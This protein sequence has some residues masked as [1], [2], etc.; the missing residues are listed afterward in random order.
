MLGR[1]EK[2]E[3]I[4]TLGLRKCYEESNIFL[5]DIKI[6]KNSKIVENFITTRKFMNFD[7]ALKLKL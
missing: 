2:K 7:V 4:K 3:V 6:S 5:K 1:N